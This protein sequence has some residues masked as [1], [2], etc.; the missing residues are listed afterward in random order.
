[1][2]ISVLKNLWRIHH[3]GRDGGAVRKRECSM[4]NA[5]CRRRYALWANLNERGIVMC[6]SIY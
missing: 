6:H 4:L 3:S 5:D 2:R 1:M